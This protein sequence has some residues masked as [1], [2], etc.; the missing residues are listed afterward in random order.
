MLQ[1]NKMHLLRNISAVAVIAIASISPAFPQD[2][3]ESKVQSFEPYIGGFP[4]NFQND[5]QKSQITAEYERTKSELDDALKINPN[6]AK[7]LF[8][9][10][11]LQ[12]M[13]HN[14]D[15]P[16]SWQGSTDDF[17]K[18]LDKNPNNINAL[19]GLASLWVNSR[20]ELAPN[21][22]KLFKAAQCIQGKEPI[23]P[24]QRGIFFAY[25]YQGKM[26]EAYNQAMFLSKTW[27]NNDQYSGFL[28]ISKKVLLKNDQKP[29]D[30][31]AL[32][33]VKMSDCRG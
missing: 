33:N 17:R 7:L 14:M 6:S 10:G 1:R 30:E 8:L 5:A 31:Q 26:N 32:A 4:P 18:I 24:A 16:N 25:Y 20:P 21:A 28:E 29:V 2:S 3:L 27:P 15:I 9:R 23:E 22:E 13:G 12:S 11:T 19:M